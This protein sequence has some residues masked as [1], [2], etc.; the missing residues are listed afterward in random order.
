MKLK[1]GSCPL[2]FRAKIILNGKAPPRPVFIANDHKGYVVMV[3]P[4]GFDYPPEV[5][6]GK[7]R[8]IDPD[9]V[10]LAEVYLK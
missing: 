8:I 1:A 7:V 6:F 5:I 4:K 2:A 10:D 3:S 9:E